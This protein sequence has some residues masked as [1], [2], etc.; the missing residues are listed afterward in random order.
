[1]S[2]D[3]DKKCPMIFVIF[4]YVSE[5][6]ALF[7]QMVL[8]VI[9]NFRTGLKFS[10]KSRMVCTILEISMCNWFFGIFVHTS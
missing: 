9:K 7:L 1:M 10:V 4:T 2:V 3:G 8:K 5:Q 6:N